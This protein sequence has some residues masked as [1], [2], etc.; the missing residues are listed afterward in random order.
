MGFLEYTQ[1]KQ[2]SPMEGVGDLVDGWA[3]DGWRSQLWR[4]GS[5]DGIAEV[6]NSSVISDLRGQQAEVVRRRAELETRYGVRHPERL[7]VEREFTDLDQ[8]ISA[9][10]HRIVASL[11]G[12]VEV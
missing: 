11:E 5:I 3:Y 8:Q 9:E 4:G 12:E 2:V 7:R 1:G 6:L 10:V